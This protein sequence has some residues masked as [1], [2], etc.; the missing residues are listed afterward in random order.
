MCTGSASWH[1][2][3]P[4]PRVNVGFAV[5]VQVGQ[6]GARLRDG[7]QAYRGSLPIARRAGFCSAA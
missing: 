5:V 1:S 2:S 6:L 7:L 3:S 4:A